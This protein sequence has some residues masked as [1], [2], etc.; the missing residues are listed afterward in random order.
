[1]SKKFFTKT[2]LSIPAFFLVVAATTE[3]S[4]FPPHHGGGPGGSR[5]GFHNPGWGFRPGPD[6]S[7]RFMVGARYPFLPAG[8]RFFYVDDFPYWYWDGIYFTYLPAERVYV[9][10]DAPEQAKTPQSTCQWDQLVL[11]DGTTL[12]GIFLGGTEETIKFQVGK[13]DIREYSRTQIA[14]IVIAPEVQNTPAAADS[15]TTPKK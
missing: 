14:S 6:F 13:N 15:T 2:S 9:V 12:E 11:T 7:F 1:M 8:C 4:A 3:L 10:V 5:S